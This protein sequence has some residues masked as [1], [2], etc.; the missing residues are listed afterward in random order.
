LRKVRFR[1]LDSAELLAQDLDVEERC[2]IGDRLKAPDREHVV[3][4]I[5]AE[6]L[7]PEALHPPRQQHAD[8]LMGFQPTKA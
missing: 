8:R 1:R 7:E 2:W 6:Q 4:G 5:E 3:A